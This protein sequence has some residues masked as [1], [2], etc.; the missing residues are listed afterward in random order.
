MDNPTPPTHTTYPAHNAHEYIMPQIYMHIAKSGHIIYGTRGKVYGSESQFSARVSTAVWC[1]KVHC[2]SAYVRGGFLWRVPQKPSGF[3]RFSVWRRCWLSEDCWVLVLGFLDVK[4]ADLVLLYD[5][6][7]AWIFQ[8][9]KNGTKVNT[10]NWT[11]FILWLITLGW[12]IN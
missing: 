7:C 10:W 12:Y 9:L 5:K 1:T 8:V 6:F 3:S 11:N 4:S 2:C